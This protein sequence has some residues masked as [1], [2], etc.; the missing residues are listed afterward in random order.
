[1]GVREEVIVEEADEEQPK[2]ETKKVPPD[3]GW[4]FV[5]IFA[6][7]LANVRSIVRCSKVFSDPIRYQ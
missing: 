5:V 7:G 4:G 6:Y 3:G 1:M 2:E